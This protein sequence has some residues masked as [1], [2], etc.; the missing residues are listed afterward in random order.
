LTFYKESGFAVRLA[1]ALLITAGLIFI[2]IL[3]K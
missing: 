3:G 1:G 2:A